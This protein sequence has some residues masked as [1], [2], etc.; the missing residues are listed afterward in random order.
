MRA[1]VW[2]FEEFAKYDP[3]VNYDDDAF[4][5]GGMTTQNTAN[6][7]KCGICG[8]DYRDSKPRSQEDGGTYGRGIIV[9]NYTRGQVWRNCL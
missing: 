2:R 3:P 6:K 9:R 7:G 1:S 5:C 8:D 4:W